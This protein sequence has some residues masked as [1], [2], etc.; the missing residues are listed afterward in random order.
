MTLTGAGVEAGALIY[1][2]PV[3]NGKIELTNDK[4]AGTA[5]LVGYA[6]SKITGAGTQTVPVI[7]AR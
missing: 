6:Y 7:L 5:G 4:A 1:A 3:A 2:K